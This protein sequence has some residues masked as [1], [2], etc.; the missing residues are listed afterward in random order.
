MDDTNMNIKF[1]IYIATTLDGFIARPDGSLDWLPGSDGSGES[2][3]QEDYGMGAF[4]ATVDALLM[5]RNTYDLVKSFDGPWPYGKVP[6]YVLSNTMKQEDVPDKHKDKVNI[7]KGDPAT[8]ATILNDDKINHVYVDGG[9]TIQQYLRAGLITQLILTKV[10]VL[11]GRGI[12]LFGPLEKDL[13]LK[14]ENTKSY[15][16]GFTQ[17]TYQV[18]H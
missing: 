16:N 5:G 3:D 2:L 7:I 9:K 4:M 15:D 1:S 18:I 10:P 14:L 8:V 12:S 6:A 11:I 17:T 13:H